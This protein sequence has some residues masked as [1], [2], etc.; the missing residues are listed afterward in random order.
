MSFARILVATDF[1]ESSRQALEWGLRIAQQFGSELTLMHSWDPPNYSYAAGLYLPV[2]I[3]T[4]I[5]RAAAARL[6]ESIAELRQRFP[7]AKS[8]LCEGAPWEQV[9]DAATRLNADLIVM[10][11]HGRSGLERA[12]LGSVAEKVV[13]MSRVPVLTVHEARGALE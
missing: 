5:E 7:A 4:P 10:G 3:V 11:T 2:D 1:G 13:R 8:L 6:E 12:L 9:L